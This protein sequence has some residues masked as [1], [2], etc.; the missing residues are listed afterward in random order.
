M[1]PGETYLI[2]LTGSL[3]FYC[4]MFHPSER[5]SNISVQLHPLDTYVL[6]NVSVTITACQTT[7]LYC[8]N[9]SEFQVWPEPSWLVTPRAGHV[10]PPVRMDSVLFP[11]WDPV[12][13]FAGLGFEICLNLFRTWALKRKKKNK[14]TTQWQRNNNRKLKSPDKEKGLTLVWSWL[15]VISESHLSKN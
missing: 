15:K 4:K 7:W 3:S 8:G 12:R 14:T 11:H 6:C 5:C 1:S 9:F 13:T 2:F 10:L